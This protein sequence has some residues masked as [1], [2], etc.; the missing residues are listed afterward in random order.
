MKER[1]KALISKNQNELSAARTL[2]VSLDRADNVIE[3]G[4]AFDL[5]RCRSTEEPYHFQKPLLSEDIGVGC[6]VLDAR[7]GSPRTF[8]VNA[9]GGVLGWL[10][11][12]QFSL[13]P[14][15]RFQFGS[16][17]SRALM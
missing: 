8:T 3:G 13:L 6:P 9:E 14:K 15:K 4:P 16:H 7:C 5:F 11:L 17:R 2:Y 12:E 10:V 1:A